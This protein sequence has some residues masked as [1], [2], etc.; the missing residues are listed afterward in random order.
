MPAGEE[1]SSEPVIATPSTATLIRLGPP[2]AAARRLFC[3]PYAGGG[4]SAYAQWWRGLPT[5]VEVVG[6]QLPGRE[7]RL[8]DPPLTSITAMA[9]SA[10]A[11]VR[12]ATDLPFAIFGHSMGALVAFEL[13]LRVEG[14]ETLRP[15]SHVFLSGRRAPGTIEPVADMTALE[16]AEFL[17]A[18]EFRFGAVTEDVRMQPALLELLVPLLRADVAAV[19]SYRA[20]L[21]RLLHCPVDVCGGLGDMHPRPVELGDWQAWAQQPVGVRLFE[22]DH[23]YLRPQRG[24]LLT[25]IGATWI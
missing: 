23:F 18:L 10:F 14:D 1:R 9:D 16:D 15:P 12:T 19:E 22:G 21:G 17:A 5:D 11:A 7:A 25:W 6:V 24:A 20:P 2:R 8:N 13:A 3:L 4:V